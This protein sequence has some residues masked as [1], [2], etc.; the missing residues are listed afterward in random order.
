MVLDPELH[1]EGRSGCRATRH[2]CF[3][4]EQVQDAQ[5][6]LR[7]AWQFGAQTKRQ[8]R[9]R[10]PHDHDPRV[11][12]LLSST[13]HPVSRAIDSMPHGRSVA[14][15]DRSW[16]TTAAR[17]APRL[18]VGPAALSL[19]RLNPN[20]RRKR[21]H[22]DAQPAGARNES[23]IALEPVSVPVSKPT[24][25][26]P[27]RAGRDRREADLP[28]T[29]SRPTAVGRLSWSPIAVPVRARQPTTATTAP[30]RSRRRSNKTRRRSA[31]TRL[32]GRR[33]GTT[34]AG[35]EPRSATCSIPSPAQ[36]LLKG[37]TL[38]A[39]SA[40]E[41]RPDQPGARR[42]R[43]RARRGRRRRSCSVAAR[44]RQLRE[45]TP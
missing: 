3:R 32:L 43:P 23:P 16:G 42:R 18:I 35:A 28:T 11:R 38:G 22:P 44:G 13:T 39:R 6:G 25:S 29:P 21:S 8:E 24:R 17:S 4:C 45:L 9:G 5:R 14:S 41:A 1:Q 20:R 34:V 27:R 19:G 37:A 10:R 7:R 40:A 33:A 30:Q 31:A 15:R 12:G 2:P 26:P 36:I